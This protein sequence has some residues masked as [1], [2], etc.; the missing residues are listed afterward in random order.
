MDR[1]CRERFRSYASEFERRRRHTR[2]VSWCAATN[3]V[4]A[5]NVNAVAGPLGVTLGCVLAQPDPRWDHC[6][7]WEW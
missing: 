6:P 2:F 7:S 1:H 3:P 5:S 4:T